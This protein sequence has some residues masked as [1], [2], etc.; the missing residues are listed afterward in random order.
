MNATTAASNKPFVFKPTKYLF[1]KQNASTEN[2][3]AIQGEPI[4]LCVILQNTVKFSIILSDIDLLWS[5]QLDNGE[6][7]TNSSLY[8]PTNSSNSSSAAVKAAIKTTCNTSMVLEEREEKT[9]NFKLLPKL[10][11]KLN[12]L[13][14]VAKV[15]ANS[16][17]NATLQGFLQFETQM[18]KPTT[19]KPS[20][21]SLFDA[22]LNI[23]IQQ[24]MPSLSVSFSAIPTDLIVGEII[25]LQIS[26]R[27]L[28]IAPI[29]EIYV[30][31]DNPR[32]ITL[33][34]SGTELPLS[35]LSCKYYLLIM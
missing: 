14:I 34:D 21:Q 10:T 18:I 20:N 23:R 28:G 9:V 30:A 25:P 22:K 7:L 35:I 11:G 12:I 33:L 24:P 27:N 17:P 1:T 5:L 19:G 8:D 31:C 15:A 2:P 4:E 32:W 13:G 29:E 16:E 6:E 3:L 26:L